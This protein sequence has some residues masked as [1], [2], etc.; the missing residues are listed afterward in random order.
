MESAEEFAKR[1]S[2]MADIVRGAGGIRIP[3]IETL[4]L[5]PLIERR[6]NATRLALLDEIRSYAAACPGS[7][8]K[9]YEALMLFLDGKYQAGG[10]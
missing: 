7:G 1:I 4:D 5:A 8:D 6:D 9:R 3:Y 2:E 10:G